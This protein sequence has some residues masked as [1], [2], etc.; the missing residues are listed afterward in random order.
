MSAIGFESTLYARLDL[1][2][3][4]L[5]RV[6][7]ALKADPGLAS[8]DDWQRTTELIKTLTARR[9]P[10]L[11][12]SAVAASLTQRLAS[13]EGEWAQIVAALEKKQGN[14]E[15][16]QRLDA[17][18]WQLDEERTATLARMRHNHA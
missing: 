1:Y 16:L 4:S 11:A 2:A 8:K 7:I 14:R 10:T 13:D 5:D 6:I 12:A 9:A 17:L 18:A 15:M 3:R